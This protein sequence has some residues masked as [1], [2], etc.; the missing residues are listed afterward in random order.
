MEFSIDNYWRPRFRGLSE[1]SAITNDVAGWHPK[2]AALP[3]FIE[4]RLAAREGLQPDHPQVILVAA[5]G[6]VGK[7]VY[8]SQ[9][10]QVCGLVLIDLAAT[11]PVGGNFIVGGIVRTFGA[12]AVDAVAGGSAGLVLDALDEARLKVTPEAFEAFLGEVARLAGNPEA[13]PILLLVVPA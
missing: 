3:E 6:A 5:P 8:A 10:A 4:P 1:L 9:L 11:E 2:P 12:A 7:S 13:K